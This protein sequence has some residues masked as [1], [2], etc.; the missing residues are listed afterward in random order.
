MAIVFDSPAQLNIQERIKAGDV[1]YVASASYDDSSTGT[2]TYSL[3]EGATSGL[4]INS[5]TGEVTYSGVTDY[6]TLPA[7]S[8]VVIASDGVTTTQQSVT[9]SVADAIEGTTGPDTLTGTAGDDLIYS[10]G[11]NDTIDGQ[12]GFNTV[13]LPGAEYYY[14]IARQADGTVKVSP[15]D[16][17]PAEYQGEQILENV[18]VIRFA[19]TDT[20]RNVDDVSSVQDA[21]NIQLNFGET[22][23]GTTFVGDSDWFTV[24]GGTENQAVHYLIY[25]S[26]GSTKL[27]T[28]DLS[29]QSGRTWPD[30]TYLD[31]GTLD[32]N[33][34]GYVELR[35]TT[36]SL[37]ALDPYK[38]TIYRDLIG[39]ETDQTLQA[40]SDFEYIDAG[41]GDDRI[42]GS[43]RDEYLIGGLGDDVILS[44]G[45]ADVIIGGDEKDDKD[46]AVFGGDFADYSV[47]ISDYSDNTP[48]QGTWWTV[49]NRASGEVSYVQGVEILRFDDQ[50]ITID[51][52]DVL[53]GS[54]I[55]GRDDYT[56]MGELIEGSYN[57]SND[58]D[59]IP[60]S[61]DYGKV[62]PDSTIKV[63]LSRPLSA[64]NGTVRFVN[65]SGYTLQFENVASSSVETSLSMPGSGTAT[66]L[67]KG[68]QW[69]TNG[70]DGPFSGGQAFIVVEGYGARYYDYQLSQNG[71]LPANTEAFGSYSIS[72]SRYREGDAG[73]NALTT[74]GAT[75]AEQV[76]E[77]SGLAGNDTLTGR[78]VDEAFDG[79]TGDD[80]IYAGGGND[81]IIGGAG[82]DVLYG[83][84]G[85]DT[86]I[87]SG[88]ST[89]ADLFDGGDGT[90][91]IKVSGTA[92]FST[93]TFAS[94]ENIVGSGA[95]KITL[96]QDQLSGL[97]R[98]DGVIITGT[99]LDASQLAGDFEVRGTSGIDTITAGAG[100]NLIR[101]YAGADTVDAGA[102]SDTLYFGYVSTSN[103]TE[104]YGYYGISTKSDVDNQSYIIEG[105][106]FGGAG[107]DTVEAYFHSYTRHDIG[108]SNWYV[109]NNPEK[110]VSIDFTQ[111]TLEGFETFLVTPST[112][113]TNGVSYNISPEN[114]YLTATQFAQFSVLSGANF[115]VVDGGSVDLSAVTLEAGA[116]VSFEGDAAFTITGSSAADFISTHAGA[117]AVNAGDGDDV[118]NT[119]KGVDTV[120]A[121]SGNDKI[122]IDSKSLVKD[123][124]DGGAG[125]DTLKITGG[126]VD[127]SE[128]TIT[129]I[130]RL[131][132]FS[133]SLS[134][135]QAQYDALA[136][137]ITGTAGLILKID[138]A[139][140]YD[141]G[142]L[143]A[144]FVGLQGDANDNTL[145]GG[146]SQ[147]ILAGGAGNDVLSG[148]DNADTLVSG[149]GVDALDGGAGNDKLDVRGKSVVTDTIDGG[150]DTDTLIVENG[151]DLTGATLSNIETLKG[152]GTVR[153]TGAQLANI[154]TLDGVSVVLTQSTDEYQ[155][156][157][158]T[159]L[160]GA[161]VISPRYVGT[162]GDDTL[163]Q[164]QGD[165]T[166]IGGAGDDTIDGGSGINTYEVSGTPD[167]FMWAAQD[168]GTILLTDLSVNPNDPKN[169][170]DEGV[171]TLTNIQVLRFVSP[172]D[173]NV[174][175]IKLDDYGNSDDP[176]NTKIGFGELVTGRF[177]Y[178]DDY[179]Y[180]L[181]DTV[182]GQ[183]IAIQ[184]LVSSSPN[185]LYIRPESGGEQYFSSNDQVRNFTTSIDGEQYIYT[186]HYYANPGNSSSPA[187]TQSYSFIMRRTTDGASGADTLIAGDNYEEIWARDGDDAITGSARMDRLFGE[188]GDDEIEG[189]GSDDWIDGGAGSANVAIFSGN[190][191]EYDLSWDQNARYD[192]NLGLIVKDKVADRDGTDTLR[193]IQILRF[194]DGDI[195]LD[196]ESN[197]PSTDAYSVGEIISGSLAIAQSSSYNLDQDYFQVALTPAVDVN[198]TLR[199]SIDNYSENAL[200][201]NARTQWAFYAAG[202]SDVLQFENVDT[203]SIISTFGPYVSEGHWEVLVNPTQYQS[204]A[205]FAG[206]YQ[207]L[208]LKVWDYNVYSS[209]AEVGDLLDYQI[210]LDLVK[211][212]DDTSETIAG[213]AVNNI[214]YID[215]RGGDD[216][217]NGADIGEEI[218]GGAGDDIINAAGGDDVIRD[219]EGSNALSGGAGDDLIDVSGT[220]GP[221]GSVDGG[222]DT[223]TLKVSSNADLSGLT[224][225]N[226]EVI[227]GSNSTTSY[228]AQ[229]LLDLGILSA[230]NI[231]FV[232]DDE[233]G[234]IFTGSA[235]AG[236]YRL[237]GTAGADSISTGTGD[238]MLYVGSGDQV[239][240][241]SGNDRIQ[242]DATSAAA[243]TGQFNGGIGTD[244]LE[245]NGSLAD[246]SAAT[247]NS[248]ERVV[249]ANKD[250]SAKLVL[251]ASQLASLESVSGFGVLSFVGG[252]AI[253]LAKL[254]ATGVHAMHWSIAD[255]QTY[256]LTG[257]ASADSL[258]L[259]GG[260]LSLNTAEGDDRIT[261][262]GSTNASGT[263]DGGTGS[264]TLVITAG[265]VD[266]SSFTLQ[267]IDSLEV[268]SE[269]LSMTQTQWA[270]FGDKVTVA[271]DA[272]TDFTLSLE[273]AG[274]VE[275]SSDSVYAGLSGSEGA[276]T[277]IGN[278]QNN[279]LTGN[280][281]NDNLQGGGGDDRLVGGE[282][283]DRLDG[284]AGA[285]TLDVRGRAI[286]A[287]T[288]IGGEGFDTLL[289]GGT[290]DLTSA[291]LSGIESIKGEAT[292]TLNAS[293]LNGLSKLN[294]V[295][296]QLNGDATD[297]SLPSTLS[298]INGARILL[299]N[300]DTEIVTS[301]GILG[302]AADDNISGGSQA[303]L[304]YG[305]RGADYLSGGDGADTLVGG[306][307]VDTLVGGAGD[308]QLVLGG[309][310]YSKNSQ[311]LSGDRIDGGAG[312]DT[313]VLDFNSKYDG[314]YTFL[315]GALANVEELEILKTDGN[316]NRLTIQ[317]DQWNAFTSIN[318]VA[319]SANALILTIQGDGDFSSD[320]FSTSTADFYRAY[321]YGDH[322]DLDLSTNLVSS[323]TN[324]NSRVYIYGDLDTLTGSSELDRIQVNNDTSF[325]ASL[326]SGDDV[327]YYS[328]YGA[329]AA[330]IDGGD[331]SDT[332]DVSQASF[333]DLTSVTLTNV[334]NVYHGTSR[335]VLTETQFA[336]WSLDG[337]GSVYTK[338]GDTIVGTS[339]A[340]SYSGDGI[341]GKF[342]GGGGDDSISNIGT[343]VFT[344]NLADYDRSPIGS[345]FT[346]Q[347]ARG[348]EEDGT[349]TLSGVLTL[350]FADTT[351]VID[352]APGSE[353]EWDTPYNFI[354]SDN[355]TA[356]SQLTA[357]EYG[358]QVSGSSDYAADLDLY[359]IT[360]VPN[361][362]MVIEG[363]SPSGDGSRYHFWD[364]ETGQKISFESLVTGSRYS[365]YASY[366]NPDYKWLP[367]V[368]ESGTYVPYEGG[369][370]IVSVNN[371][372]EVVEDYVFTIKY[373]DD[374][375]GSID[376]LGEMDPQDGIIRGYIGDRADADWIRTELI[377]GTKY[378]FTLQGVSSN[379]G[380]LVDP[381]LEL[382]DSQ[383]RLIESGLGIGVGA[384]GT[385]DSIV[386]RPVD[387]GTYYLSVTDVAG[388]NKGSWTL[389][390]ESL[391]TIA[392][393]VSTTERIEWNATNRFT[394]ESEINQLSDH[395]WFKIW[396]D[397][398]LTYDFNLDSTTL[399]DPQ[400]SLRS[401]TG[402]LLVQDDNS[403]T[404]NDAQLYYSASDSGWYFLDAGASGNAYKGTYILRGSTLADDFSNDVN[405][406]GVATV[407][408]TAQGLV[409]YIGDSDWFAVGLSANTT[410]VIT[411]AGDIADGVQLDPLT[412]PLLYIR[413][414]FGNIIERVD[415]S[416]GSLNAVAY[417]TPDASGK[418][419]LEARSAFKYDIGAYALDV[420]L[421]P[422]DDHA[423][424]LDA[425]ATALVLDTNNAVTT[426]GKIGIPGDKD[427]FAISFEAGKIYQID[428]KGLAGNGGTLTDPTVRIFNSAGKLVDFNNNSGKG[429]DAKL[430]FAPSAAGT[431]YIEASA[432]R[433]NGRGTYTLEVAERNIPADDVLNDISTTEVLTPGDSVNK[434]LLTSN[435]QD[436]FAIDLAAGESYV[437]RA[438]AS[439]SGMG[440]LDDP[441]LE[442]RAAD[443]TL[444][445]S[446]DDMLISNEPAIQHTPVAS[447]RFYLVVK[448]ANGQEDTGSYTLITRAPD[449][450]SNTQNDATAITLNQK[451][452]GGIQYNDGEF[453]VRAYDSVGLATD[454]DE[455]WFTFTATEG[456][457]LSFQ[458]E[459]DTGSALSRPLVEVVNAQGTTVAIGDGLETDNGLAAATFKASADGTYY[460]RV[461]DGAGAKGAYIA[462][463]VEGDASD[464][465]SAG[466]VSLSFTSDGTITQTEVLG[467]IG[468]AGDTD[469][470]TVSL[471][472]GHSYR[473]ET[474][475]VRDGS[476][477][478][479][480]SAKLLMTWKPD[481]SGVQQIDALTQNWVD[482]GDGTHTLQLFVNTAV[483][484]DFASGLEAFDLH[485]S[486][487]ASVITAVDGASFATGA[488][489][490]SNLDTAGEIT[491]GAF[492]F[493]DQF[494]PAADRPL[495]EITFSGVEGNIANA[496]ISIGELIFDERNIEPIMQA[497]APSSF[498]E[499]EF[500]APSSGT[501]EIN[502]SPEY[503]TST[504]QYQLRVV[505]LGVDQADDRP[506]LVT[507]YDTANDTI[508]AINETLSGKIDEAGDKD[509][510]AVSLTT[511]NIYDF[512]VKSYFDGLGSLGESSLRLLNSS[513][514]LVT[515]ASFDELTGRSE[516]AVSVFDDGLYYLEVSAPDLPGNTGTY[517]VDTRLRGTTEG[518]ED[519]I[520]ADTQS[521]VVVGPGQPVAG[522][523]NYAG[524]HD[525]VRMTLTEG[526]V[527]VF[528]VLGD[529]DGA[530]TL[531]DSTLRL[532]DSAGNQLVMDDDAGA[533]LDSHIQF[534]AGSTGDYYLD[535][536]SN[537]TSTG[538]YTLRVRELYSGVADPL[539][540]TQ[541]YLDQS[542]ISELNNQ[543]TGAGIKVGVV[544]DGIDTM[545]PDLIENLDFALAYDTQFDTRDGSPK[546]PYLVGLPPDNHGTLVAGIIGAVANNETGLV[547]SAYDVDLVS[548][549]V[550]WTWG[551]I[552]E[553][554]NLQYQF[555]VSNNS[556]GAID[557]FGDNFN[558][559]ELTFAW[560]G[561]RKGVEDGRGGLG[562]VFVFSAGN[563]A[564]SGD[565]T[566]YHNFQNAR[567]VI[568][569][570]AA[571]PD[572]T[573]SGFST[574]G[575]SVLISTYGES[576]VTTDRVK[577][578]W[579]VAPGSAFS[580]NFSGTS[581]AAPLVSGV[582]ALML[583]ANPDLGY[584]DVQKILTYSAWHPDVQDW[585]VNGASDFNLG[586]L[587]FNDKAGFGLVDAYSAVQLART[588][589]K[590]NTSI[591][592]ATASAR[593]FGLVDTI[594]DGT[595][596][597]YT[598]TF[599]IDSSLSV[600]HVELGID[601]RHARMGDLI[602]TLTS[603]DGTQSTLM[604]RPTVNAEL[605]FGL[606]G[607]AS[608]VPQHLL[609]DFS[610]VQF[611]GESAS[612]TWT[613]EIEDTRAE[614]VGTLHSLS[615]RLYGEQTQGNDIYV[616]TDEGFTAASSRV[617]EDEYGIDAIN[618]SP[619]RFDTYI[620]LTQGIIA[621]NGVGHTIADWTTIENAYT[622]SGDDRVVGNAENNII[623]TY[624]GD[625]TI[626]AGLGN[627]TIN[628]GRGAD[629][630]VFAGNRDE[631]T[632]AW[633]PDTEV[634]TV[635][636]NL[637]TGGNE[638]VNTLTGVERLVFADAE[639]NLSSKV[640]N[641][642]PVANTTFFDTPVYLESGMG[643]DFALPE[644]AFSDPDSSN[645]TSLV[646]LELN[647]TDAAGGEIPDWLTFDPV[648]GKFVGVPPE[649]FIGQLKLKVEA[650]DEFGEIASDILTLQFGDNQA[651]VLE[652]PSEVV[653]REDEGDVALGITLPF[654]PEGT[655]VSIEIT[656]I[657]TFGSLI[658][659]LGNALSVGATL[660]ADE[661]TELVYRTAA[662]A[663]GDAGYVRYRATDEDGVFADSSVHLFVTA[664]N[665]AP[666]FEPESSKL[667]VNYSA[668]Q[669]SV[670]VPL[671][672]ATPTDAES[673]LEY[674]TVIGLPTL[675]TVTLNNVALQINQVLTFD[676][677]ANLSYTLTENVNGP[678][679]SLTIQAVDPEGAATNFSL[680][681]EISGDATSTTGT[682]GADELYG[683]IDAD[684]L[685]GNG[686][687]DTLVGNAGNDRLL[688][689]LG[690]DQLFGGSGTDYLDGSAGKDYLDGGSGSDF[691]A[692]GP[693][694]DTYL[695]DNAGDVVLEVIGGGVGGNDLVVTSIN[696]TAPDN[697]ENLTAA[698]GAAI[699]LTGNGLANLLAGNDESN[700]LTGLAGRDTLLGE[701]GDDTLDGGEGIDLMAG[702][703]GDDT[704]YVS[705]R[706]DRVVELANA[707]I[708]KVIAS[709]SYTLA[710]NI[711]NLELAEG[712]DFTAGGNSLD[713]H[714]V[715]N[716]GNNILAGG[717][718]ADT[719]EGGLGNDTYV[720]SDD[721]DTIIDTGGIDTLRSILDVQLMD[722]I[723]N[724]QLVGL[725]NLVA[726]G[727][728]ANNELV[729]N[730]ADNILEG[731]LG[732]D[733]L[734]G[735][736]GGDQ[737]I[738]S[739]NGVDVAADRITDFEVGNDLLIVDL[740]SF[741]IDAQSLGLQSSG[742][743]AAESFVS[744]AGAIA[745]DPNDHFV[746]DTAQG[747]LKFDADGSGSGLAIDVMHITLDDPTTQLRATDIFVGI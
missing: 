131:E 582:V 360:L 236:N 70:E 563:S 183:E 67:I 6:E 26:G 640:G 409:S 278:D 73:D 400:L 692:G 44:G 641:S 426:S 223:D 264:N 655:D 570:G 185:R 262:T 213:D 743:V 557:Q 746:F 537:S 382:R 552:T 364:A 60:F 373:L 733:T 79:G 554:L 328:R 247:L 30:T 717:L 174:I 707:G 731:G 467:K 546:Y 291:K 517:V 416:D 229:A 460:A 233:S 92:D 725:A 415:D 488:F 699:D 91:T 211:I 722:G 477:A 53:Q 606:S 203:G 421:A 452:L 573:A 305:G 214:T 14:K 41:A 495:A 572:N 623:D 252:G 69:G 637:S 353:S 646:D 424:T 165:Q 690:N 513:G 687:N 124:I 482:N 412:D 287:D 429:N 489:G 82:T 745:L 307:G 610:S 302:S 633:N 531:G 332:L 289:V 299:P 309:G 473:I 695:V 346:I 20:E 454:F 276:D 145:V 2:I 176:S 297:F 142:N 677:L 146:V 708:D 581:A 648:Q 189:G 453:G 578:G 314:Q 349:D 612:G 129:G 268:D 541:W 315:A 101:S 487:N 205:A 622:G 667:V 698:A 574:P 704:Y 654:D 388:I 368:S 468:L 296:V 342:Q 469:T 462:T 48:A 728:S 354:G 737:F 432:H 668:D 680:A 427:T 558:S 90:D 95:N 447:G 269:S 565:N 329:L 367:V 525:W 413:D 556:W 365:Y 216:T 464:E 512:S 198:A 31:A 603:P 179:D 84:A 137:G 347:H 201:Y 120:Y 511:G 523:I 350:E 58:F 28:A 378:E 675:G 139:G 231:T 665:D 180:F 254:V 267:N 221:L 312:T 25:G 628:A 325:S 184:S 355:L 121:G 515:A 686:G 227:D 706:S 259:T 47:T 485:F 46:I 370:V 93:A 258:T 317:T 396:L 705:S 539:R 22:F 38:L 8:F 33:G 122:T 520:S 237:Q 375:A 608:G 389:V 441:V 435:D 35:N 561:L 372:S 68:V 143:P 279:V 288:L 207:R 191:A 266:L 384:V 225:A 308:D 448:A 727:N 374:Y 127:L 102:G 657:P 666:V 442:L 71:E 500:T 466:P 83:E 568:T 710:S 716:S 230:Q 385:D 595:G 81:Q 509:L 472:E 300:T 327:L 422:P 569:V 218:K 547:G 685:Y 747:L 636:D 720:L 605:P 483:A 321:L 284:G 660:T 470:Y 732:V 281:G 272:Y 241:G 491:L 118:I 125:T 408:E 3:A 177:D 410:Y 359:R 111:S 109:S 362:P 361:S 168:D 193:N 344:G 607:D 245:L 428:L 209:S 683:S 103:N 249:Q 311:Q 322:G 555:D 335:I 339:S 540:A 729:G 132:A 644:D 624:D 618:A 527:Y 631:F 392:G 161:E 52:Y 514:Q 425:A 356:Y 135:T 679:G 719:L 208:D 190:L 553:A 615:L 465:D 560:M 643:I 564:G 458:V 202:S 534:T 589:T 76:E 456:Q 275:L 379:G 285:D 601:I 167:A 280:G 669:S 398:G 478:P 536:G 341:N 89:V 150:A 594:P 662:D 331:G 123:R 735:G 155:I 391:D 449:D 188:G 324:S 117:D 431:Y 632:L 36:I 597:K 502:L 277:L 566:N 148:G 292:V 649:D 507:D 609:W 290:Q 593:K 99:S 611:W 74:D 471:Q 169:A 348:T 604:N 548:T 406:V 721:L 663:N 463:L 681:L 175:E 621:A 508:F 154:T 61:F 363:S 619:V 34:E 156:N 5:T 399:G 383:G 32:A 696:L 151:Q 404:G 380:T 504:G 658:D 186:D 320:N 159:L 65:S 115:V 16:G 505:D 734:T 674:V 703:A 724:V 147:D 13:V 85:D 138:G 351:V 411:L 419:Y 438:K 228:S 688:G 232:L 691:M 397:K 220:T 602:I 199:I 671:D 639:V 718:G 306:K 545:H 562:T 521:A 59:W 580:P 251:T 451:I 318:H 443:G 414:E 499:G 265:D 369:E 613:V 524:D 626:E 694:D 634:L 620:D 455:D 54:D 617:L 715:G 598:A 222:A 358:K 738:A 304:V 178:K 152:S 136:A 394:V 702:G 726:I 529:G 194:N 474:V 310:A 253:D 62:T 113:S 172:T 97:T 510:F 497:Q 682:S 742:L 303:D 395:D 112:Y 64:S 479:L 405:T 340:D 42:E 480:D 736:A 63:T 461:I 66:Y 18:Q 526:K 352:D 212:G 88:E 712:G 50:D 153:M 21:N 673:V 407:G 600:E 486:Y 12:A 10:E 651:P 282:G 549:R 445:K 114:I 439:T 579:G 140:T 94:I 27:Y 39:D 11:G 596:E 96:T 543:Y 256:T 271:A 345:T 741:G 239:D 689:G 635:T 377:G 678:V 206:A 551:Q 337:S 24:S 542:F 516:M 656:G 544:D 437:F 217:V 338:V 481:G 739:Y 17:A 585:K 343:A 75:I 650:V 417:F 72:I 440:T 141:V 714:I 19:G 567:E 492:F 200:N 29:N 128:T 166:L 693:G 642:A 457:V 98:A 423:D 261:V 160:N 498:E 181:F 670:T 711:E 1:L 493:P 171:D 591:N 238:N 592:E 80:T 661:L 494:V 4:A 283:I 195:V 215:A 420:S 55:S 501:L 257:T 538:T 436:W 23:S 390:Q 298:L 740:A 701:G 587:S 108:G 134:L 301:T 653:L 588:W 627:D 387:T 357:I 250:S 110:R 571:A 294:G 37:N 87:V 126:A 106:Y 170:T 575:A 293:Q 226:I 371:L 158:K 444:V 187:G 434:E 659:K 647:V 532:L 645:Q 684:A 730:S 224:I 476:T 713:N 584:R 625:D 43:A 204:G 243:L 590:Q 196:A 234:D 255:D 240:A 248:I 723:E 530:G 586:G 192:R 402:R 116:T 78:D 496:N 105:E 577:P 450:H 709:S 459:L 676:Q 149:E 599:E 104:R 334:E 219:W 273:R 260:N 319:S 57:L 313:L 403:G 393:N 242:I 86:F 366:F 490:E 15:V 484:P 144:G 506:N 535:V 235:L 100:N 7:L 522:E 130:E 295:T 614:Q 401:A 519:D 244:S 386:F 40:G 173:G 45:G 533:G 418:Y 164:G 263:V 316:W 270:A 446:V 157:S 49:K 333:I 475:A 744:G 638:G 430:F 323:D 697:V 629:V 9:L 286:V 630:V 162:D 163:T 107:S 197:S 56:Y 119:G 528:D 559:T 664:E 616:F 326:G 330:T 77:L 210:R 433:D 381:K 376:T 51:D 274:T 503:A 518:L 182:A 652:S 336:N 700:T 133:S 672:L 550:K 576:M 583:E 246:I